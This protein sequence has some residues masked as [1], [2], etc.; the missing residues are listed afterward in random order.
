M[1][2]MLSGKG[3][4]A[5]RYKKIS[6]KPCWL[7]PTQKTELIALLSQGAESFGYSWSVSLRIRLI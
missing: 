3:I 6:K 5:M 4:E 7:S 2:Q 1:A